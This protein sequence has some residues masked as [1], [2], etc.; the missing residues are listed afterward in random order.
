M[1]CLHTDKVAKPTITCEMNN[2]SS[3]DMSG[4]L[5][6]SAELKQPQSLMKFEWTSYGKLQHGPQ[7][8]I[9]LGDK[10]DEEVYSCRVS[11]PLSNEMA[12]FIA[13]DCYAGKISLRNQLHC[14]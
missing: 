3:S 10:L 5:V 13:K 4:V 14:I 8:T 9:S 6:C 7:L 2:G 1:L 11:N 12:T